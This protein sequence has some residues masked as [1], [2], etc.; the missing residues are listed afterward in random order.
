MPKAPLHEDTEHFFQVVSSVSV[1]RG[2]KIQAL[3]AVAEDLLVVSEDL[4]GNASSQVDAETALGTFTAS[5]TSRL[6][7]F[8]R[9]RTAC[10]RHLGGTVLHVMAPSSARVASGFV[11]G[12]VTIPPIASVELR[13]VPHT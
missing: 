3:L 5:A 8:T 4:A 1:S 7:V 10:S 6:K 12:P 9:T 13:T 11:L 2:L